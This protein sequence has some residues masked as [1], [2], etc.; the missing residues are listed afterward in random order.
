M[1]E[2]SSE[3][4]IIDKLKA[5][6]LIGNNIIVLY[7]IILDPTNHHMTISECKNIIARINIV[8]KNTLLI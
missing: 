4:H 7:N 3:V 8:A 6:I 1:I 5:N 2:L